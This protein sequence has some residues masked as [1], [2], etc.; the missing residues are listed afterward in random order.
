METGGALRD[1]RRVTGANAGVEPESL[2]RHQE[3]TC[4][5]LGAPRVQPAN[6]VAYHL[7]VEV[8]PGIPLSHHRYRPTFS[9]QMATSIFSHGSAISEFAAVFGSAWWEAAQSSIAPL[10]S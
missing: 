7:L 8:S 1:S 9:C 2:R 5:V 6:A 3:R 4:H 10:T